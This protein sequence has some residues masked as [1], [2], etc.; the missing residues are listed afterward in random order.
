MHEG[1]HH[2]KC[3]Y[4]YV[5]FHI[6][7]I[8]VICKDAQTLVGNVLLIEFL[9]TLITH[10]YNRKLLLLIKLC[11]DGKAAQRQL[12]AV[13]TAGVMDQAVVGKPA[14]S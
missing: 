9:L 12:L 10:R 4:I 1:A 2:H 11:F 5:K 14:L 6:E 13:G 7:V 3:I 8:R